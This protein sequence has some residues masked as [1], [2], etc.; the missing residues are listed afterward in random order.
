MCQRTD[1][2]GDHQGEDERPRRRVG[3]RRH[4]SGPS[5]WLVRGP[6]TEQRCDEQ[7]EHARHGLVPVAEY[8]SADQCECAERDRVPGGCDRG[9]GF[10]ADREADAR[11]GCHQRDHRDDGGQLEQV[12]PPSGRGERCAGDRSAR[13]DG[14]H[15][16]EHGRDGD[17]RERCAAAERGE[18]HADRAERDREHRQGGRESEQRQGAV[19]AQPPDHEDGTAMWPTEQSV[20]R[21]T[22]AVTHAA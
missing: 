1:D 12:R 14:D 16:R 19:D 2:G 10:G 11:G 9:L 18:E 4:G 7:V 15:Q 22:V 5:G 8:R 20:S 13:R 3:V 17:Q 21:S 6:A